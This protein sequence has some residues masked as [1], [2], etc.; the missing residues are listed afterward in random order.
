M[1]RLQLSQRR[2]ILTQHV[3]AMALLLL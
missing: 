3:L 2:D 1:P